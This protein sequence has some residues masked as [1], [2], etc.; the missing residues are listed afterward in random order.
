MVPEVERQGKDMDQSLGDMIEMTDQIVDLEI[1]VKHTRKELQHWKTKLEYLQK[2]D[3][4]N[5][6]RQHSDR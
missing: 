1:Q 5:R 2:S 6:L 3:I 4:V